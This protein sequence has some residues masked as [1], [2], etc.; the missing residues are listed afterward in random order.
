MD[1]IEAVRRRLGHDLVITI[2]CGGV[3]EDPEGRILLQ[4]RRAEDL[5]AVPG[6]LIE[7]GEFVADAMRRE[8]LEE[9]GLDVEVGGLFG[10]YSGPEGYAAY[11]NGDRVFSVML[12][13]RARTLTGVP[14]AEGEGF[15][16]HRFFSREEFPDL[17]L[18]WG[19]Q[20]RIL[21]D[22]LSG[23]AGPFLR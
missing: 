1:Y 5:W 11:A 12:I 10:V 18:V 6:G 22:W 7:P 17:E 23:E 14:R 16:A 20:R 9:T 3:I 4:R 21:V 8:A 19:H 15:L 2:G 13:M